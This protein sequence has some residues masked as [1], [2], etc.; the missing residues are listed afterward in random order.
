MG[1]PLVCRSLVLELI[2]H[3]LHSQK[4]EKKEKKNPHLLNYRGIDLI[5]TIVLL[6]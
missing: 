2:P 3:L 1:I 6:L 5:I 4:K